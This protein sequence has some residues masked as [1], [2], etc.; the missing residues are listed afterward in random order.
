MQILRIDYSKTKPFE[1]RLTAPF[2]LP[3]WL[4]HG[5]GMPFFLYALLSLRADTHQ[6]K[7]IIIQ[8]KFELFAILVVLY[9]SF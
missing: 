2:F 5:R 3:V 1:A 9:A 4:E 8:R 6:L 7:G